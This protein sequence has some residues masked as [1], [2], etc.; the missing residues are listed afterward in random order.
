MANNIFTRGFK[1]FAKYAYRLEKKLQKGMCSS[2]AKVVLGRVACL[3]KEIFALRYSDQGNIFLK[4]QQKV[5]LDLWLDWF[6]GSPRPIPKVVKQHM[7]RKDVYPFIQEQA[8]ESIMEGDNFLFLI[9]DSFAELTDQRFTHRRDGWSFCCHLSDLK[10]SQ[11]FDETFEHNGLLPIN[12]IEI[13]YKRFFN[14]FE[15]KYPGKHVIFIHFPS[16]LDDRPLFKTRAAEILRVMKSLERERGFIKNL[17]LDDTHVEWH[18]ND[19]FPYHYSRSTNLA[20]LAE[21]EK[22]NSHDNP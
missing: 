1:F 19:Q 20:F 16:K 13:V 22:L 11:V 9:M 5:R 15:R 12:E 2:K 10:R 6:D 21:W 4:N 14:W 8:N 7:L 3:G 17:S 18:E